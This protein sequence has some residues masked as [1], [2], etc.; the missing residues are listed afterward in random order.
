MPY[1]Q[2]DHYAEV[3]TIFRWRIAKRTR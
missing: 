1:N 3:E 2:T